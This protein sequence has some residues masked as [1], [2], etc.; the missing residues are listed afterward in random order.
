MEN[1]A[2][3][4]AIPAVPRARVLLGMFVI[5]A[6]VL[7]AYCGVVENGFV[8]Y[9]DNHYV[10]DNPVVREGLSAR[11][12]RWAF[13][14]DHASNWHPLTWLSHM[15]DAELF[16]GEPG[17]Q[18]LVSVALHALGAALLFLALG[19]MTGA[20][21]PS[22]V[23]ALLFALH[24]LRV[25]SVAW[26]SERKDV[27]AGVFW[28]LT[29]LA[30]HAYVRRPGL[31]RYALVMLALAAGL[32][33]K[34]MLVTLP[35]VLLLLDYWPLER[36]LRLRSALVEKLPLFALAIASS[37][38]TWVVQ[39]RTGAASSLGPLSLL[40][41][42]ANAA[43]AAVAYLGDTAWPVGLAVLYPHPAAQGS[44]ASAP[45]A[46]I[47][48]GAAVLL[49]ALTGAALVLARRRGYPLVG[50]LWYLGVLVPVL[51][52]VQVGVQARA[53]R[54]T[55]LPS[56][57]LSLIVVWGAREVALRSPHVRR[58]LAAGAAVVILALGARTWSQVRVWEDSVSLWEHTLAV[59][60]RNYMGHANY[61]HALLR[62]G[63]A[64]EGEVQLR[65]ALEID[66][67][68]VRA[69]VD[70]SN[71]LAR[72]GRHVEGLRVLLETRERRPD[73]PDVHGHLGMIYAQLGRYEEA[74]ASYEAALAPQPSHPLLLNRL[75]SVLTLLG[76]LDEAER[77]LRAALRVD[78]DY[79]DAMVNLGILYGGQERRDAAAALF[80]RALALA[81]TSARAHASYGRLCIE[82][83]DSAGAVRHLRASLA[84][85]GFEPEYGKL[86]ARILATSSD[87]AVRDGGEAVRLAEQCLGVAQGNKAEIL[88]IL[89]AAHAAAGD[90]R[91]AANFQRQ[92][93]LEA[94]A[95]ARSEHKSRLDAYRAGEAYRDPELR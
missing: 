77:T 92:A 52:L 84:T 62:A 73:D 11:G 10:T 61:G 31:A 14:S 55:Y 28:M 50:W 4:A 45:P 15:L 88:G 66:P 94:P 47:A 76:R 91:E 90:L 32:L 95:S 23:A 3:R 82:R 79:A 17:A 58:A 19:R 60:T 75:G 59:T 18:H 65:R 85:G 42:L 64:E 69:S 35:C 9:D 29:L 51:G 86:L 2:S 53:D 80:E 12:L 63:R 8:N 70:L 27:L 6:A 21:W 40:D 87:D 89:A 71:C 33:A 78:P 39:S 30:Y 81:P 72:M 74:R 48:I 26:I 68:Y 46:L 37:A 5:V 38:I 67:S 54:Y 41:R 16:G 24:P 44:G 83:G 7:G 25:E 13:T 93:L 57:G 22:L 20:F 34:P 43:V 36:G 49:A 56:V 1:R